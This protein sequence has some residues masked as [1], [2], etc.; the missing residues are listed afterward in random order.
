MSY[1]IEDIREYWDK[2][3]ND[4]EVVAAPIGTSEFFKELEQ[5]RYTRLSYL[6]GYEVAHRSVLQLRCA[7]SSCLFSPR[8]QA[9]A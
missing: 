5:Y 6:P 8:P 2:Y 3:A 9:H 4:I 1:T 7:V